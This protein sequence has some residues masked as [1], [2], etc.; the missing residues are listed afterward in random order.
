MVLLRLC[1]LRYRVINLRGEGEGAEQNAGS[2]KKNAG[3][4]RSAVE[5]NVAVWHAELLVMKR[6]LPVYQS[7]N[8]SSL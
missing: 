8:L 5:K 4:R 2:A 7:V 6:G 1:L 3:V